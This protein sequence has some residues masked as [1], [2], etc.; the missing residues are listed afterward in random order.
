M[1]QPAGTVDQDRLD[2]GPRAVHVNRRAVGSMSR[3][4]VSTIRSN[5]HGKL[6]RSEEEIRILVFEFLW[7]K[8]SIT[9]SGSK[10]V[11]FGFRALGLLFWMFE[12]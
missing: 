5:E 3:D 6:V 4:I 9:G 11:A 2:D 10:G 8:G 1:R 7:I 12:N